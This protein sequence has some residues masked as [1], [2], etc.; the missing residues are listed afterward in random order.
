MFKIDRLLRIRQLHQKL[1]KEH[2]YHTCVWWDGM[3]E[4]ALPVDDRH[5]LRQKAKAN[6]MKARRNMKRIRSLIDSKRKINL[7][8]RVICDF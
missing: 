8:V 5:A 6:V 3:F 7:C 2:K 4:S 1:V